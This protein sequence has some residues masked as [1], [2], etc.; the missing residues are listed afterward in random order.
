MDEF[1]QKLEK[2]YSLL[3]DK[4]TAERALMGETEYM[5]I[6]Y[7]RPILQ[8]KEIVPL[9]SL[10]KLKMKVH[11]LWAAVILAVVFII[12]G[13]AVLGG[14]IGGLL[15]FLG[16]FPLP[17]LPFFAIITTREFKDES[18]W[19][20]TL[21]KENEE[22]ELWN[23]AE[24]RKLKEYEKR[25]EESYSE[26]KSAYEKSQIEAKNELEQINSELE[27]YA[28]FVPEDYV[29]EEYVDDLHSLLEIAESGRA[30]N[31]SDA[32]DIFDAEYVCKSCVYADRCRKFGTPDCPSY[33]PCK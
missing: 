13:A 26:R 1:F 3:N 24:Y 16:L 6:H 15:C 19:Q 31:L 32:I 20:E 33:T 5:E 23:Q 27:K 8:L 29:P 21:R 28:D 9:D 30:Y 14:A 11:V 22:K 4:E 10:L 2:Y 7:P 25:F 12:F 18:S 17:I